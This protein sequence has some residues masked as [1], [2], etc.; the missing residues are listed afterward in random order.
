MKR[1]ARQ[2]SPPSTTF[3]TGDALQTNSV[4]K[5]RFLDDRSGLRERSASDG[6]RA[7]LGLHQRVPT[8]AEVKAIALRCVPAPVMSKAQRPLV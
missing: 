4:G 8:C 2:A 6:Y 3:A 1:G 5:P 7:I